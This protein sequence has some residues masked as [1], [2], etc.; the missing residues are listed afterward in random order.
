MPT[1][2]ELEILQGQKKHQAR[3]NNV[4]I[5]NSWKSKSKMT[6]IGRVAA[7]FRVLCYSTLQFFLTF[8]NV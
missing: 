5:E 1:C 7:I 8:R 2:V 4:I 3:L 6:L